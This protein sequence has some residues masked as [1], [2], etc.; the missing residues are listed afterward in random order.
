MKAHDRAKLGNARCHSLAIILHTWVRV[1]KG[2]SNS[3]VRSVTSAWLS[4]NVRKSCPHFIFK[5]KQRSFYLKREKDPQVQKVRRRELGNALRWLLY[6][7]ES[8]ERGQ[9]QLKW[10]VIYMLLKYIYV[11][12]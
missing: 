11:K 4:S 8:I 3:S 1:L 10:N 2:F 12:L 6:R 9:L 7:R 5:N